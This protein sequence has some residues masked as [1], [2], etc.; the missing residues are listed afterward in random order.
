MLMTNRLFQ[1]QWQRQAIS[2]PNV[3]KD[4]LHIGHIRS[5]SL[6][7]E[8]TPQLL[9]EPT[10]P[11]SE[12]TEDPRTPSLN[13]DDD[14]DAEIMIESQQRTPSQNHHAQDVSTS[15]AHLASNYVGNLN[16]G[17][18]AKHKSPDNAIVAI[19]SAGGS[20]D[21][22]PVSVLSD[23]MTQTINSEL[24]ET[25]Y[26]ENTNTDYT[27]VYESNDGYSTLKAS[28][29]ANKRPGGGSLMS[30]GSASSVTMS[31]FDSSYPNR[32]GPNVMPPALETVN[33]PSSQN[34]NN[35]KYL[36]EEMDAY[37]G[38]RHSVRESVVE[39]V[40]APTIKLDDMD[41]GADDA[42]SENR[43]NEEDE[44]REVR[45]RKSVDLL[46][47]EMQN[48]Y[49]ST[50]SR[51][52]WSCL[53]CGCCASSSSPN[54]DVDGVRSNESNLLFNDG[55]ENGIENDGIESEGLHLEEDI[56]WMTFRT[57]TSRLR[58]PT[59]YTT[60]TNN[61]DSTISVDDVKMWP[62][63]FGRGASGRVFK[64]LYLPYCQIMALKVTSRLDNENV[65]QILGEFKQQQEVLPDCD[66]LMR[67]HGWYRN[68]STNEIA[69]ALE[70][71]DMGSV[72]DSCLNKP[73]KTSAAASEEE[74]NKTGHSQIVV[75]KLSYDQLRYIARQSLLGLYALHNNSPPLIHRDIKP[76]NILLSSFGSVKIADFGLLT[77][78]RNGVCTDSKGTAKYFSPERMQGSFD[79]LADI[80]SL[81]ITLIEI[82]KQELI[83]QEE[84]DWFKVVENEIDISDFLPATTPT[85]FADFLKQCLQHRS[86]DR[87]SAEQLL[88]HQFIT[89]KWGNPLDE[90]NLRNISIQFYKEE[91]NQK[92]LDTILS[93]LEV[94]CSVLMVLVR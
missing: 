24:S 35:T 6:P 20:K 44:V 8:R 79:C 68:L 28:A 63:P 17:S 89:R 69:V 85:E 53:L 30:V 64:G 22:A 9:E 71:M 11:T 60:V 92:L 26:T 27:N 2:D 75:D 88:S 74:F 48:Q 87:P 10:S 7:K 5:Y 56:D 34:I 49:T 14:H 12:L 70:Y 61:E 72:Y 84:L 81:G 47:S 93:W 91:G 40:A 16:G 23:T 67:I 45:S 57:G 86:E 32:K 54:P 37:D 4:A 83:T 77:E 55:M 19:S 59:Q 29:N 13:P 42:E 62:D 3:P 33:E 65:K 41:Y 73:E 90:N 94:C 18:I 25:V 51:S 58:R 36:D 50:S 38:A 21:V 76:H 46:Q 15:T 1:Q 31:T 78:L 80:W 43:A 39:N 52:A 66:E 82:Y